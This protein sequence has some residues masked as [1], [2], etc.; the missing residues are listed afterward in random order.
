MVGFVI[1][2]FELPRHQSVTFL[3]VSLDMSYDAP[4]R[5]FTHIRLV[6]FPP[7]LV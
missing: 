2:T 5:L 3:L 1:F 7:V 4:G 6:V